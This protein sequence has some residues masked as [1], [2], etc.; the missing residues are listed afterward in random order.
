VN[1][2]PEY[3][4]INAVESNDENMQVIS[5]ETDVPSSDESYSMHEVASMLQFGDLPEEDVDM[6]VEVRGKADTLVNEDVATIDTNAEEEVSSAD[7]EMEVVLSTSFD[8]YLS[9][10]ITDLI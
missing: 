8:G 10:L 5:Q 2:L 4:S 6:K 7:D 9:F 3:T 1:E